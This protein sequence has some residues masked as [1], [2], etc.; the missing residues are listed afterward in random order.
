MDIIRINMQGAVILLLLFFSHSVLATP[1][2]T[3][4]YKE[5]DTHFDW[6][7]I[8]SGKHAGTV[9][10]FFP[11]KNKDQKTDAILW[12]VKIQITYVS[13]LVGRIVFT[14]QHLTSVGG[15]HNETKNG[16]KFVGGFTE[17]TEFKM[18]ENSLLLL[19]TS[20]SH[21]KFPTSHNDIYSVFYTRPVNG[22][23]INIRFSGSHVPEPSIV[24][25]LCTGLMMLRRQISA[26]SI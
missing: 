9:A 11:D 6:D 5:S 14:G 25:L 13:D 18:T 21:P 7:F 12:D 4:D 16:N 8:W 2:T 3:V 10:N 19:G 26:K 22:G 1:I 17:S 24:L 23:P 15:H 20:V